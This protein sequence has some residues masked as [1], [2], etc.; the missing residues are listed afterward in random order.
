MRDLIVNTTINATKLSTS[1][2]NATSVHS[3]N[4]NSTEATS[5]TEEIHKAMVWWQF[6]LIVVLIILCG[7]FSG[8]NIGIMAYDVS[9]LEMVSKG[10]YETK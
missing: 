3:A 4:I 1:T 6:L 7:V 9:Y 5:G 2:Q 8:N 10:P